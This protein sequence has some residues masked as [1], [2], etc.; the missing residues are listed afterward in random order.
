MRARVDIA[1]IVTTD[2]LHAII[3]VIL[4]RVNFR[5]AAIGL[6]VY[7]PGMPE[8]KAGTRYCKS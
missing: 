6:P 3:H 4:S 7:K 5:T 1:H 8:N 2:C